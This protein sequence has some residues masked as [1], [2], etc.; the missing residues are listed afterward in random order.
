MNPRSLRCLLALS[1]TAT[2]VA[3]AQTAPTPPDHVASPEVYRV[4]AETDQHRLVVGTWKPG[5]RD[6]FHSHPAM[7]YYWV[8]DCVVRFHMPE[9]QSRDMTLSAGTAG[10]QAPVASHAV[11][12]IGTTECKVVMFEAK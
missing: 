6:A 10:V 7:V 4:R 8:T 3:L 2:Q 12:N 1:L 5:Q 9:G 11:E